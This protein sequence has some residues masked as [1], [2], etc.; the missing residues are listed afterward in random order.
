LV[1]IQF[2]RN[3]PFDVTAQAYPHLPAWLKPNIWIESRNR[4]ELSMY[5]RR[6]TCA[7]PALFTATGSPRPRT[8]ACTSKQVVCLILLLATANLWAAV[9]IDA[10]V[11]KNAATAGTSVSAPALSTHSGS[12]LLLAYIATDYISGSN[13]TVTGVSGGGLTWALVKRTNVQK[14]S[15]EIWRAFAVNPLTNVVVTATLSQSVISSI[16]VMGYAGVDTSGSNGSGA[17]GATAGANSSQGAPS[18]SLVTTR[19][20]S[21]VFG[22]G[23]DYDNAIARTP[24]SGQSLV[25]QYLTAL[26]DTYWV[27][28]QNAATPTAGTAVK[29]DDTAPTGD[30]FN[31]S[32]VEVL[33]AIAG[34]GYSVSGTI[35]P[36][37][38]G[39][40]SQLTLS[41]NGNAI[42]SVVADNNGNYSF[43]NVVN[44]SY[45]VTPSKSGVNFSPSSQN[46]TINGGNVTGINFVAT[47]PTWSIS[48]TISP[49]LVGVTLTLTGAANG[50]TTSDGSGNYSFSGLSNGSYTITPSFAGYSFTPGSQNVTINGANITGVNFTD[51]PT[52]TWSISGSITPGVAGITVNLT[53]AA[54]A[55]TSTD[56]SGNYSFS[57]LANGSY[58][59]T[60]SESGYSF[61]PSS[62]NVGVNNANVSGQNFTRQQGG[63]LAIDAKVPGDGSTASST[64]STPAFSTAASN[65][66]LLAFVETDYLSGSNT[67]V[68]SI[69]GGG[70]TWALVERTN[71]QSGTAEVWRAFSATTL[72][73]ITVTATL[74]QAVNASITVLSFTGADTTGSNGAGAIGAVA[75]ANSSRGAPTVSLVTTRDGSWV[76]AAGNDYD[77]A[78]GRT[79]G[80][81]QSLVHQ[82]LSSTG[83][84]YWVQMQNTPT[85][86]SGTI[87]TINDK[88]PTGD[89][90]NLSEVEVLPSIGNNI[91]PPTVNLIAPLPNASV[92]LTTT[93]AANASDSGYGIQ[94]VQ[95]LVDGASIGSEVTSAPYAVTWDT[96]TV[97]SGLH[98]LTAIA[99]NN[100]HVP[101][102]SSP[103]TVTVDNSA[104]P[105]VVGSW[106]Q[107]YSLPTVAVNLIL[108][109]DNKVLFYEDGNTPTVWDYVNNQFSAITTNANL[110]CSGQASLAD[111]RILL[112][113][114]YGG[115]NSH[116]GLADAEIFD[117][118]TNNFTTIPS[119]SYRRWYP[120]ATTLS[121]GRVL[122]TAGWQ[123]T[124]HSNAGIPEIYNPTT[125]SW[126]QLTNANNPF[127]TYPFIYVLPNGNVVHV[128]GSEYPTIT[129]SLNISTQTWTTIDPRQID[130]GSSSMYLPYKIVKAGSASDSQGSGPSLNTTFVIDLT[131][132]SPAWVQAPSMAYPRSFMNMTELPDGTVLATGGETDKNGGNIANAVYAGEL[133][134]SQTTGWQTMASMHTP[135]EYHSTAL[136]LPDGRVLQSGMGAD[137]GNVPNETSAEFFSP[138]YLFKGARPTIT[139][140]PTQIHYGQPFA[141]STPNGAS[142]TSAVLIRAGAA[143]HF[144]DQATRFV[145][146]SFQVGGGGLTITAPVDGN[147]AP[148]GYYML[149]VVNSAGVPSVAPIVQ[150]GP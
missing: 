85:A 29:I 130:G 138:P 21:W 14:G 96:T 71:V 49:A 108:L 133:W 140:A 1:G 16:T 50:S 51:S 125:N 46:V 75:S 104:N 148:P 121:D 13:T 120:T 100:A 144:F 19:N 15:A 30:S 131:Q 150:V 89:R 63:S 143:T 43:T 147:A 81:G 68:N 135:R 117:P 41:Q 132:P 23:N 112:V 126:S 42:A 40:G 10:N 24:D 146:V 31:L 11:S 37:N 99:Y 18:A 149:F 38:L 123:T 32:I 28:M 78:I 102:T 55:S 105:A 103:V 137:F 36:S 4:K 12:E 88:A 54:N 128:G 141:I 20:G 106:S 127:E 142:I 60:P 98:T 33:P 84:T 73:N 87:V 44:G 58:T 76:F 77:N 17:V 92:A 47:A 122:V 2:C 116:I 7:M 80:P 65:E 27:Q 45:V 48:G 62:L 136:L 3:L 129:E 9:S 56:S 22:V 69:A 101:A 52:Q 72:S 25:N 91:P 82:D 93:V 113:G 70:L 97:S 145:P 66:L 57:G 53:G 115:D 114:G 118:G 8:N 59:V 90:Y 119:M 61:T 34:S 109:R 94:G 79:P 110:F 35:T 86:Q 124:E 111:G 107:V 5:L 64:V 39:S 67:K 95:F 134:N 6:P 139:S 26:G 74:S 83:D